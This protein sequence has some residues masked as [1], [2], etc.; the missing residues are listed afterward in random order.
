MRFSAKRKG[1]YNDYV[2]TWFKCLTEE[3]LQYAEGFYAERGPTQG[4]F[5]L[6]GW[7][8]QKRCAHMKADLARFG[9]VENGV[10]TCSLHSWQWDL[11]TGACLTSDGHQLYARPVGSEDDDGPKPEDAQP[12]LTVSHDSES[13]AAAESGAEVDAANLEREPG[14]A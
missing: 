5:E 2:Y 14:A 13:A 11:A 8:V 4:T 1:P 6:D 10:L 3:R 12:P 9:S 7:C